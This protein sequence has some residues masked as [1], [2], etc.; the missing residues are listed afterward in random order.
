[1]AKN[2]IGELGWGLQKSKTITKHAWTRAPSTI[3]G[4]RPTN[5][6]RDPKTTEQMAFTTPK[7]I[8]T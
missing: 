6:M 2:T 7:Q 5:F 3:M 4:T 8:M 1:M